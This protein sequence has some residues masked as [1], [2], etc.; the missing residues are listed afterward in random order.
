MRGTIVGLRKM[1]FTDQ[2]NR[3]I[4]GTSVYLTY[5]DKNIEGQGTDKVFLNTDK[6][7][8]LERDPEVGD[9]LFISY[10]RYGKV[11]EVE[12]L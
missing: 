11:D 1:K 10:N 2:Q 12:L 3:P 6:I 4:E 5:N 8:S 9:T 7:K